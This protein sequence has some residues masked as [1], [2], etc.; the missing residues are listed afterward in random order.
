MLFFLFPSCS[1]SLQSPVTAVS[2]ETSWLDFP[3]NMLI[4]SLSAQNLNVNENISK[5][6]YI[7]HVFFFFK[8][9]L[10]IKCG[11]SCYNQN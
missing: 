4:S 8:S 6:F 2:L 1:L 5:E 7:S 10:K 3:F 9:K 11:S